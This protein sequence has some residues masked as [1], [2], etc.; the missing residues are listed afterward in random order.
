[1][2]RQKPQAPTPSFIRKDN[3]DTKRLR[4]WRKLTGYTQ[5]EVAKILDLTEQ[6][7]YDYERGRTPVPKPVWLALQGIHPL[8][9]HA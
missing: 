2:P 9:K 8:P 3:A 4:E 1:M 6:A 5:V 7:V